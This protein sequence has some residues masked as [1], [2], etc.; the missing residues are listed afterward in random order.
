MWYYNRTKAPNHQAAEK[1][2]CY[3]LSQS[4]RCFSLIYYAACFVTHMIPQA[5]E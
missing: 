2:N 5:A 4:A 3:R 1:E